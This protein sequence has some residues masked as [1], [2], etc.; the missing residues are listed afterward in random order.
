MKRIIFIFAVLACSYNSS[1]QFA[2]KLYGGGKAFY[3]KA[4]EGNTFG[5]FEIGAEIIRFKFLAPEIGISYFAGKPNEM[6]ILDLESLPRQGSAKYDGRFSSFNFAVAPK[7][8]FGNEEA[9][10]VILP[11]YN[12]GRMKVSERS[13]Q[14][15]NSNYEMREDISASDN[16]SFWN[17][18]AGIEGDFFSLESIKF[19][20]LL[21]YSTFDSET[22]FED[23]QFASSRDNYDAGSKDA[24]GIT[25]RAYFDIF[26]N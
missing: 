11:E 12:F 19:S 6:E 26:K 23:L 21:T 7:L 3:N 10:L 17:F 15:E 14:G 13:F 25:F 16:I 9:A 8:I 1:A 22:A 18:S 24:L 2:P 20:L 5:G 4:Y